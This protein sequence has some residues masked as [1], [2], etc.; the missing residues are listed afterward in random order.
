MRFKF[1]QGCEGLRVH[2][3]VPVREGCT[4]LCAITIQ[5]DVQ[6]IRLVQGQCGVRQVVRRTENLVEISNKV[7]F[8]E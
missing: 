4:V 6:D 2:V 8:V 1:A 5:V 3:H 7:V